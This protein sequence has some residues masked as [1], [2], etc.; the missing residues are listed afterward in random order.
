M[1]PSSSVTH[2]IVI[3]SQRGSAMSVADTSRVYPA[4][5]EALFTLEEASSAIE[6]VIVQMETEARPVWMLEEVLS[7]IERALSEI[8]L[9]Q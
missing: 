7:A 8:E 4:S 1:S 5:Q 6:R 3:R 2:A 9:T